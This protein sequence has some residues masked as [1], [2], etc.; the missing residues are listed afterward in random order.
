M[1][2]KSKN[3]KIDLHTHSIISYDGGMRTQQYKKLLDLQ[4]VDCIA[5]TDHNETKFARAT[6]NTLG[7]GIIIGEEIGTKDGEIIGLFLKETIH[8]GRTAVETVQEIH[9]QGGI[10]YIPHPFETMRKGVQ[11][12]VL[13]K[14]EQYIDVIEVFNGRARWFGKPEEAEAFAQKFNLAK[15]ASSDAHCYR[16]AG[17]TVSLVKDIPKKDTLTHLLKD[18]TLKKTYAPFY[19]LAC[20]AVN[21]VKNKLVFGI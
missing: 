9:K 5:I 6:Q 20:P 2:N 4:I 18:A 8:G 11:R 1:Q 16:G 15:A 19:T 21:K 17:R 13:E 12:P 14:I 10:V 7:E 3:Y